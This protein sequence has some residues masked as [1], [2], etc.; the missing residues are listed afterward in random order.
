MNA[1]PH[2]D[3]SLEDKARACTARI[4]RIEHQ[5]QVYWA[6]REE[7]LSLRLRLQKGAS[8]SAFERERTALR[9]LAGLH[10]AIPEIVAEG[11]DFF[12]LPDAGPSLE[13]LLRRS[14]DAD[15]R[16][17]AFADGA[18]ALAGLHA[19]G[20]SHGRPYLK[21][22]CWKDGKVGFIDFENYS[23][24]RN[25]RRGHAWDVIIFFFS[26]LAIAGEPFRELEVARDAYRAND[27]GGVWEHAQRLVHR[28]RWVDWLTKPIQARSGGK[29][30]EFKAIPLTADW[31]RA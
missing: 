13:T 20:V 24:A 30:K 21:D 23:A 18:T 7:K 6:K 3:Q 17:R 12:V 15:L 4:C 19:A 31:F 2:I 14:D 28:L 27:P 26:G 16:Q 11:P 1:T 9:Q 25:S 22:V 10:P 29:A 5:G 8:A